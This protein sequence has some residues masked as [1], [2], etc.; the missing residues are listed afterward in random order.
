VERRHLLRVALDRLLRRGGGAGATETIVGGHLG[1]EASGNI[2]YTE[3]QED[4]IVT[5]RVHDLIV[6]NRANTVLLVAKDRVADIRLRLQLG[7]DQRVLTRFTAGSP[8]RRGSGR[9]TA[10]SSAHAARPCA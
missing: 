3:Q 9:V 8:M 2:I 10:C 5:V 6:V 1:Y 4:V 7:L